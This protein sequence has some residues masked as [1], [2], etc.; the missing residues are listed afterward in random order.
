MTTTGES[1]Q[2]IHL[3]K[4]RKKKEIKIIEILRDKIR[5]IHRTRRI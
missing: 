4:R 1:N 5:N 2:S 3:N